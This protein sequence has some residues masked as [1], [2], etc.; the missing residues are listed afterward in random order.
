MQGASIPVMGGEAADTQTALMRMQPPLVEALIAYYTCSGDL[1]ARLYAFNYKKRA[2]SRLGERAFRY[3]VA[4][5]R[6]AFWVQWTQVCTRSREV[7]RRNRDTNPGLAAVVP[8][9]PR[10]REVPASGPWT[11][12]LGEVEPA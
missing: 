1:H 8:E 12:I 6:E 3:R 11:G 10:P 5:A 2:K 9:V 4:E 7:G